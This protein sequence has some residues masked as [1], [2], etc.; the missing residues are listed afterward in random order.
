MNLH[1]LDGKTVEFRLP[2]GDDLI[3]KGNGKFLVSQRDDV[4]SVK[5]EV[6]RP[7]VGG[8]MSEDFLLP[9]IVVKKIKKNPQGAQFAYSCFAA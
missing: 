3:A 7:I 1:E 2:R 6:E 9:D 5:I 4:V 8:A